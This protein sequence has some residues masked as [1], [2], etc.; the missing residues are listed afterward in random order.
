MDVSGFTAKVGMA[1]GLASWGILE[2]KDQQRAAYYFK[3]PAITGCTDAEHLANAGDIIASPAILDLLGKRITVE[4]VV[5]HGRITAVHTNLPIPQPVNLPP[6]M[7][8]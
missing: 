3:G 4:R 6:S 5:N 1:V 2:S 8:R 7:S